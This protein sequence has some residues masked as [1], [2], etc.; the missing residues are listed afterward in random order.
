MQAGLGLIFKLFFFY[1]SRHIFQNLYDWLDRIEQVADFP[2][3]VVV[4]NKC[5]LQTREVSYQEAFKIA[6]TVDARYLEGSLLKTCIETGLMLNVFILS[7]NYTF[8]FYQR[9][10]CKRSKRTFL[11]HLASSCLFWR[12]K[13]KLILKPS[14]IFVLLI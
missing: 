3:L 7:E 8:C 11:R 1:R 5:D 4:G 6:Q 9:V 12:F 2:C 13:K 10:Y 14:L